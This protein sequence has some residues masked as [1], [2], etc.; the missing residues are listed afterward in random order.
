MELEETIQLVIN[1]FGKEIWWGFV[2]LFV[3]GFLMVMIKNFISNAVNYFKAR[4]SDIGRNQKILFNKEI[5]VID[6][7]TFRDIVAHDDRRVIHIPINIYMG[8]V[9]EYPHPRH[10]DFNEENYFE[11]P[12]DGK[13]ER[14]AER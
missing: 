8:S 3:T 14:R 12:W 11:P 7:I 13:K 5:F 2:T 6:K 4:M 1:T 9:K 10:D